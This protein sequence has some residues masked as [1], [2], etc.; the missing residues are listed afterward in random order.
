MFSR[1]FNGYGSLLS[2]FFDIKSV[3]YFWASMKDAR[4]ETSHKQQ[5]NR[6]WPNDY[7]IIYRPHKPSS[8]KVIKVVDIDLALG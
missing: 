5:G 2:I 4:K 8:A 6:Y 3:N 1:F 7:F